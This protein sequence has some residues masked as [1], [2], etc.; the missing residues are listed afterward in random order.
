LSKLSF[1][2]EAA[3]PPS[4]EDVFPSLYETINSIAPFTKA[5]HRTDR[6]SPGW[7]ALRF[8]LILSSNLRLSLASGF[9]LFYLSIYPSIHPSIHP[10]LAIEPFFGPWSLFSF[11]ILYTVGGTPWTGI[12]PSRGRYLHRTTQTRNKHTHIHPLLEWDSNPWS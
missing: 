2:R 5:R 9:F 1:D 11:L 8:L 3:T 4:V 12:R 10:S 7:I 6:S